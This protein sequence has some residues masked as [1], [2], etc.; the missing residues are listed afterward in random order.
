MRGASL[1]F[2]PEAS[3]DYPC[4]QVMGSA[5]AGEWF[6]GFEGALDGD[7]WQAIVPEDGYIETWADPKSAVWS[8]IPISKCADSWGDLDRVL[9]V[10][11]S[12]KISTVEAWTTALTAIVQ[13][14]KSKHIHLKR[15][16][17]AAGLRPPNDRAC[18]GNAQGVVPTYVD[19]AIARVVSAFP[20]L[21][22]AAPKAYLPSCKVFQK[23]GPHLTEAGKAVAAKLYAQ[24]YVKDGG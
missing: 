3:R 16:E 5:A 13:N 17:L 21:V 22:V 24:P 18:R 4:N 23:G 14:L 12:A 8:A 15:I 10:A 11:A 9:F 19:E 7:K 1:P 20:R 6:A 2:D